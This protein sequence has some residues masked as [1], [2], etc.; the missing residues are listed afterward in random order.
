MRR[1][2]PDHNFPA[3]HAAARRLQ[4]AGWE[5]V[6]PAENFGGQTDLLREACLRAD[7]ALPTKCDVVTML[8]GWGDSRGA[9]LAYLVAWKLGM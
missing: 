4:E 8:P 3:F 5:T 1:R 9:N 7:T 2:M 6:D